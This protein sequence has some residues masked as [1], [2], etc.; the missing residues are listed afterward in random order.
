MILEL[1]VNQNQTILLD[2]ED[3]PIFKK[4]KWYANRHQSTWYAQAHTRQENGKDTIIR[5]HRALFNFPIR[6]IEVDHKDGNGLNNSRQNLRLCSH[7]EN[8]K[9][10]KTPS[11]NTSGFKGVYRHTQTGKWVASINIKTKNKNLGSFATPEE[12]YEVYC[13]AAKFH[14]GEFAQLER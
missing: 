11:S 12:A 7:A 3:L 8:R 4:Y 2:E 14:Y 13:K 1:L 10:T 5:L 6:S 9:N